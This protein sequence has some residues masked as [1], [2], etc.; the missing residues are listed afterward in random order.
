MKLSQTYLFYPHN[1]AL[2]HALANSIGRLGDEWVEAAAPD[3]QVTVADNFLYTRGNYEQHRFSSNILDSVR[4]ALEISLTDEYRHQEPSAWA[5]TQNSLGNILAA[6]GQQQRDASL[7]EKAIQCFNNALDEYNRE[8][9]PLDWAATQY[10]L[11]TAMQALGRQMDGAKL[12]KAAIDAY[13]NALLEWSRKETPEKWASAMHQ[14]GA[15]FHAHGKLLKGNR[16]FQKSVVAYKNALAVLDADNYAFEL[17]AAHNNCG[18]VLQHLGESEEN[19]DR[20]EEAIRSYETALTVCLEQQLPI[21]LAVLC[22]VNRS[23]VRSVLAELT[24]DTTLA[25]EVADEFEMII[26]CF[27]HALQP[28]CLKHCEEQIHKAKCASTCH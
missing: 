11:G 7:Y 21:H 10:N 4:E 6:Q 24:K 5:E 1:K 3:T 19:P 14:L 28:L 2:E 15:T 12:L 22:R 20:L 8:K 13:T 18:A 17:A 9:S 25:H 23:T 16:T 27:P 26:E